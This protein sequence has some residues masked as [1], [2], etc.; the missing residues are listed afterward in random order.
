SQPRHLLTGVLAEGAVIAA[1]GVV[2]GAAGGLALV[3]LA[4]SYVQDVRIPGL[5]PIVGSAIVLLVAAVVASLLPAPRAARVDVMDALRAEKGLHA[6]P[7][8][9]IRG[10]RSEGNVAGP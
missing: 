3:R 5:G 1:I 7:C 8:A 10:G 4:G 6:E 9:P 2:A